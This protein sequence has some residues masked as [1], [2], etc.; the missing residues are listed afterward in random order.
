MSLYESLTDG[1]IN[2]SEYLRLKEHYIKQSEEAEKQLLALQDVLTQIQEY[3][4]DNLSWMDEFRQHQGLTSLDRETAV[5]LVER[6]LVYEDRRVDVVFRW[7]D[8]FEWQRDILEHTKE[9][10]A[11]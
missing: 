5:A 6:I 1:I 11:V 2:K 10:E 8:E 9:K 7:H 4:G 3:G